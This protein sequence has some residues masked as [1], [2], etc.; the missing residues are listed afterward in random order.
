M[1]MDRKSRSSRSLDES[2]EEFNTWRQ[3][4]SLLF[5]LEGVQK[6]Q[7]TIINSINKIQL[8]VDIEKGRNSFIF[9]K[10]QTLIKH[11]YYEYNST[12][13]KRQLSTWY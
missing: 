12:E 9:C 2:N 13:I 6:E 5:K 4:C 3:I 7:E 8:T 11:R 10:P 1:N